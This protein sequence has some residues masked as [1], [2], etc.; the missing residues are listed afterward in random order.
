MPYLPCL[1]YPASA[2]MPHFPSLTRPHLLCL[3]YYAGRLR[4]PWLH[5]LCSLSTCSLSSRTMQVRLT[6]RPCQHARARALWRA[7]T[8]PTPTPTPNPNPNPDPNPDPNPNPDPSPNQAHAYYRATYW[9]ACTM[10]PRARCLGRSAGGAWA[11]LSSCWRV[12]RRRLHSSC[13]STP[14]PA[15]RCG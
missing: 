4:L 1:T 12:A 9:A 8:T 15:P 13:V 5:V 11:R 3:S 10:R 7:H 2:T 14:W 6:G